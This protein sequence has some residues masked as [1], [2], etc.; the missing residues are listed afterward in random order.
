MAKKKTKKNQKVSSL[1]LLLLVTA[2]GLSTVAY[3]WFTSNKTVKIGTLDVHVEAQN[4]IQISAD[5][6][7]W[8]TVLVNEDIEAG[9]GTDTNQLPESMEAVSTS[10]RIDSNGFMEMYYGLVDSLED[11][12]PILTATKTTETK[13]TSGR[14]IAFDAFI[15]VETETTVELTSLSNVVPKE[16]TR[17]LGLQNSARV[18]FVIEGNAPVTEETSTIRALKSTSRNDVKIWEPNYDVHTNTGVIAARDTYGITTTATGADR[19]PYDGLMAPIPE[20]LESP[21]L[22]SESN[23]TDNATYFESTP[24][25]YATPKVNNANVTAFT[26]QPGVTKIR[27]YMWVEGQDV[28]CENNASGTNI[29]YNIQLTVALN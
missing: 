12:T 17:D 18:A 21:V 16:G 29:N 5:A 28:D 7:N 14:F 10:G 27:F 19:I 2:V 9:Y 8:K 4:G 1:L 13:G 11:G 25:S 15:K 23:A 26:L 6:V 20:N 22:V 3:A 24:I